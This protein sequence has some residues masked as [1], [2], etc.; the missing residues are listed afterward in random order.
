MLSN[1]PERTWREIAEEAYRE[2]DSKR[3]MELI[4]ELTRALDE[5]DLPAR[6]AAAA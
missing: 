5:R 3:F 6:R 4:D 1:M 2:K